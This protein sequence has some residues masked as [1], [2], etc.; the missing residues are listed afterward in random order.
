MAADVLASAVVEASTNGAPIGVTVMAVARRRG[1]MLAEA[2]RRVTG[3]TGG[4]GDLTAA[5]AEVLSEHGYEPRLGD[6]E[7]V[8]SNCP[9]HRIA[10]DHTELVCAMNHSLLGGLADGL[11]EAR[12]TA[13]MA[14]TTG[15]CCVRLDIDRPQ[16]ET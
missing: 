2:I 1:S 14:P 9:F 7:I 11:P 8:L 5:V 4:H 15:R 16:K 3:A 10:A 6:A 12:L 13:R